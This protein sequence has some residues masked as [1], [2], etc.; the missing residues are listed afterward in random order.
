MGSK[1]EEERC[2]DKNFNRSANESCETWRP[3][4]RGS[5]P[6]RTESQHLA[7]IEMGACGLPLVVPAVGTYFG[8][9]G[10]PGI[11][12]EDPTPERFTEAIRASLHQ[13]SPA[14]TL[15]RDLIRDHWRY[16][17]DRPI[18]RSAWEKLIEEVECST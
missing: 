13:G 3:G 6:S 14:E 4:L 15:S 2:P 11:I 16:E 17:F 10:M 1:H 12:V 5:W 8:R 7:G 18:I 9:N